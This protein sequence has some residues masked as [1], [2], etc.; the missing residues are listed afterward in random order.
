[1]AEPYA[2]HLFPTFVVGSLPRP[3]W[4]R[5]VIDDRRSG[6]LTEREAD[7]L[8]NSA[9]PSAIRLQ[10]RAGVDFISDGEWRRESYVKVFS[11]H[12]GG[13]RRDAIQRHGAS[14]PLEPAVTEPLQA[15]RP[16]TVDAAAFLR[17]NTTSNIIVDVPSPFIL[18]QR[19]WDPEL[20]AGVYPTRTAF[21]EACAPIIREEIGRLLEMGVEQVQIDDPE[22]LMLVDQGYRDRLGISDT[23]RAIELAVGMINSVA[24]GHDP[25]R[26]SLHLCHG[27]YNRQRGTEGGYEPIID[28]LGEV[29]VQRF[30][31][32]FAAP[33]SHGV[34]VLARFPEGKILGLGVIDHCE[35]VVESPEEVV[36]RVEAALK[37]VP[38]ERVT[39]NPDCGFSPSA[40]NPMDL[41][42]AYAKLKAMCAGARLLRSR[43]A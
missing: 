15:T 35:P 17:A 6:R 16:F 10:E 3:Q 8:L 25:A 18:G 29:N 40:V 41:D 31:M 32:E 33:Q 43:H 26:L 21:M 34:D 4:V 13:F 22:L 14:G 20:S 7:L 1:M 24:E 9:V 37:H 27:H 28:A 42:E 12:V 36:A 19:M 5:D 23:D 39:I 38:P 30:A 2:D 11:D